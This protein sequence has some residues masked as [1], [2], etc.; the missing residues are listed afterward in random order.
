[1]RNRLVHVYFDINYDV[2]W[3][4]VKEDLPALVEALERQE[5]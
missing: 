5:L 2:V 4:T 3:K 1:M